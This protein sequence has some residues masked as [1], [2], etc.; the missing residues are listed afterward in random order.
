M[1]IKRYYTNDSVPAGYT[2]ASATGWTSVA[3]SAGNALAA[4]PAGTGAASQATDNVTTNPN[5]ILI[6]RFVSDPM[7]SAGDFGGAW[8]MTYARNESSTDA[9]AFLRMVIRVTNNDGSV[10]RG[11]AYTFQGTGEWPVTLTAIQFADTLTPNIACQAGD[12][13]VIE[14][15]VRFTNAVATTYQGTARRGGTDGTD[16]ANGDTG[17]NANNRPSH[18]TFSDALADARFSLP[19]L[20][21]GRMFVGYEG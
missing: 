21:P 11:N 3:T 7:L 8:S 15:G 19:P 14:W 9:N 2:L 13:I 4:A 17:T 18:I 10:D 20:E 5:D 16:L 6:R 12:R 1:A